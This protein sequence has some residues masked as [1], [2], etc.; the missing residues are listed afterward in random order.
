MHVHVPVQDTVPGSSTSSHRPCPEDPVPSTSKRKR[1][2]ES[3]PEAEVVKRFKCE[4]P[5][6]LAKI[7]RVSP[8]PRSRSQEKR[9]QK[10]PN[11]AESDSDDDGSE[12]GESSVG[13]AWS[14]G[15]GSDRA[16]SPP[17]VKPEVHGDTGQTQA[18]K[19]S[20]Y[21]RTRARKGTSKGPSSGRGGPKRRDKEVEHRKVGPK[22]CSCGDPKIFTREWDL[23]R[24]LDMT[25]PK[26]SHCEA[27][28][29]RQDSLKRHEQKMR[30][31]DET[32]TWRC[33]LRLRQKLEKAEKLKAKKLE[34]AGEKRRRSTR[35]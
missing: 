16:A 29:A 4:S 2:A 26:C 7:Q 18:S 5:P 23:G 27:R 12:D 17:D 25:Q 21:L 8:Q 30:P 15:P 24:H 3:E 1:G 28:F 19:A 32:G 11:Y 31:E 33:V 10:R 6:P 14:P 9:V 35:K 20:K 22:K 34:K 13:S